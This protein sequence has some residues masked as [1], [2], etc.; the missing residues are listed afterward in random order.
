MTDFSKYSFLLSRIS[1]RL[2]IP[3]TSLF[4]LYRKGG[5]MNNYYLGVDVSKG[6]ADFVM[7]DDKKQPIEENFQLDDTGKRVIRRTWEDSG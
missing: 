2:M 1:T 6:Y 4:T 7:L 5:V 3:G